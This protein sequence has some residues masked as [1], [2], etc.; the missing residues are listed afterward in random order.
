MKNNKILIGIC[1]VLLFIMG[2]L[3]WWN[4]PNSNTNNSP[5]NI[6]IETPNTIPPSIMV[7][8]EI[9]Y[10]T[11]KESPIE[12][13]ES[14]IMNAT[15]V[16]KGVELPS[17]DGEINFPKPDAKYAKI[18]DY[19]EYVVVLMD[20]EWVRFEKYVFNLEQFKR[21]MKDKGYKLEV[22]N[23]EQDFIP[24]TRKRMIFDNDIIDIYLFDSVNEMEKEANHIDNGGCSYT[25]GNKFT[26]VSW[27]SFPHFYKKGSLIVQYIGEDE[28]IMSDLKDILG[29]QFAGYSS[30][31]PEYSFEPNVSIIEGTL[32][33]RLH[34]GPPNFGEDPDND[35]EEYPFILLLDD[36]IN[37]I[38]KETDTFNSSISNISEIQLVLKGN[39]D[40][41][42]AKQYKNRHIK[43]QGTLF[44]A[45]TGHHHTKVLMVVDEVSFLPGGCKEENNTYPLE[46]FQI[47]NMKI[48][49]LQSDDI[50]KVI[51]EKRIDKENSAF[52][53]TD[54]ENSEFKCGINL[55]G[56][57]YYIGKLST[58]NTPDNLMGIEEMQVFG[59]KAVKIYG[60]LGA[61]YAQAFYW[62]V[63]EK[64]ED[65]II[66]IDGN[67]IE[68]DL[69]DDDE[70]EIISTLGTIPETRI[71]KLKEGRICAS[72]INKS[73]GAKSVA[74]QDKDKKLF[75]VYLEPNKPEPYIY[76]KDFFKKR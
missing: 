41:D 53:F 26:K 6:I 15:S 25:N 70:N 74:L 10:S 76:H 52:I 46:F 49:N 21:A 38:A 73:I 23:A 18:N 8:G 33:T 47:N 7:D 1:A 17:K 12:P 14:I 63:E 32:I 57:L 62:F 64:P 67:T 40:V 3:I 2:G 55:N 29:Q 54:S 35:E 20:L 24:T 68:I 9:Y 43:V 61:N 27:T 71:Y 13:D 4:S 75:E 60:I 39:P 30:N 19:E 5:T 11:G 44:S 34:Y 45:F 72:D 48:E 56:E 42:M 31:L 50:S 69:D 58:E 28:I 16:I 36:P 22:V 51:A 37:V 65:S 66:Q 59:K